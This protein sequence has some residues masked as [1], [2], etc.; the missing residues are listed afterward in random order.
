VVLLGDF[1][2]AEQQNARKDDIAFLRGRA[3]NC[4]ES[5]NERATEP[6]GRHR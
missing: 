4:Y 6:S 2:I 3:P 1:K 5:D